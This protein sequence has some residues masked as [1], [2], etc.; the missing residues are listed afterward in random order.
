MLAGPCGYFAGPSSRHL[1]P[2][3]DRDSRWID[4]EVFALRK[5]LAAVDNDGGAGDV[6]G[7]VGGKEERGIGDVA[8]SA[9]TAQRYRLFHAADEFRAPVRLDA[10]R[11]NIARLDAVDRDAVGRE[12]DRRCLDEAVDTRLRRRVV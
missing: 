7:L 5:R 9:E 1:A 2:Y 4:A 12:F 8:G 10:F 3:A 11:E 6:R